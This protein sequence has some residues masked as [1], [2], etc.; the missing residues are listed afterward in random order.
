VEVAAGLVLEVVRVRAAV[1]VLLELGVT[2][3]WVPMIA[4]RAA[5]GVLAGLV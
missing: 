4:I 5:A 3:R 1:L 2:V